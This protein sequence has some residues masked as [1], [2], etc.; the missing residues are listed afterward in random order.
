MPKHAPK[1][2]HSAQVARRSR[3]TQLTQDAHLAHLANLLQQAQ[4]DA[5]R[6]AMDDGDA[7]LRDSRRAPS[8]SRVALAE[9]LAE[10][11]VRSA[12]SAE[13]SGEDSRGAYFIEE[14]GGPFLEVPASQQLARGVDASNPKGATR[15]AFPSAQRVR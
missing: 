4:R 10:G 8:R 15:A 9:S 5:R 1:D 13:E 12:T 3:V 2:A 6:P 14:V 11:F 7:F